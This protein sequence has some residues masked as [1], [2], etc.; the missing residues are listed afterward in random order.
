MSFAIKLC[1][2]PYE[3]KPVLG[4]ALTVVRGR[5]TPMDLVRVETRSQVWYFSV[6]P[7]NDIGRM[8]V[9]CVCVFFLWN[10]SNI[11]LLFWV[12]LKIYN[13]MWQI[14]LCLAYVLDHI[15]VPHRRLGPYIGHRHRKWTP[16][17]DW[18][19]TLHHLVASPTYQPPHLPRYSVLPAR[20]ENLRQRHYDP[21][22]FSDAITT[23]DEA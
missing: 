3:P 8:I 18:I 23:V 1:S 4:A 13:W 20:F 10:Q 16:T 6:V 17:H 15:L 11:D 19:S 7:W 21:I 14:Y 9:F 5:P 22:E 2:E 12:I